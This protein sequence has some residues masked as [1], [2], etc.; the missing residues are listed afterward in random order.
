MEK[1][2]EN[3]SRPTKLQGAYR[4]LTGAKGYGGLT[5]H[6]RYPQAPIGPNTLYYQYF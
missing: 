5:G 2:P 4:G 3:G 6:Y 1:S